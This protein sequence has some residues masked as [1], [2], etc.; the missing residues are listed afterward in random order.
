MKEGYIFREYQENDCP[1]ILITINGKG[2]D[3]L[4][5]ARQLLNIQKKPSFFGIYINR[6]LCIYWM[7]QSSI[8]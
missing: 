2:L 1:I 8:K 3:I 6:T 7:R 4:E 5:E